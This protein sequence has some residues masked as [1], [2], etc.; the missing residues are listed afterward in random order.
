M[1]RY[2][3]VLMHDFFKLLKCSVL[4]FGLFCALFM[5]VIELFTMETT[6]SKAL[7]LCLTLL[8]FFIS[9]TAWANEGQLNGAN[10]SWILTSTAL[11]L[12]MTLP[13]V[14]LFTVV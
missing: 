13:G 10:T 2:G 11:V 4:F 8:S 6:M 9:G 7:I 14:A 3:T 12:L 5:T 1:V